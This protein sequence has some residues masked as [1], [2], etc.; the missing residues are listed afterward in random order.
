MPQS[1]QRTIDPTRRRSLCV[2]RYVAGES[3]AAAA[4]LPPKWRTWRC[5]P[6]SM[7]PAAAS[8][9]VAR[10][11]DSLV[12]DIDRDLWRYA[13]D[14]VAQCQRLLTENGSNLVRQLALVQRP[15]HVDCRRRRGQ[16]RAGGTPIRRPPVRD[17][18]VRRRAGDDHIGLAR[19]HTVA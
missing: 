19:R 2:M 10:L 12:A 18:L 3:A 7:Q 16:Q 1:T 5:P 4:P 17:A 9:A 6:Q 14:A 8:A 11:R 15:Q 13:G